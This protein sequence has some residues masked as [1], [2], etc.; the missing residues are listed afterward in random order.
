MRAARTRAALACAVGVAGLTAA[1]TTQAAPPTSTATVAATPVVTPAACA[2]PRV[3]WT[4]VETTPLLA[5]RTA[6][7]TV[8]KGDVVPWVPITVWQPV[9]GATT[10]DVS[11][12]ALVQSLRDREERHFALPGEALSDTGTTV[13]GGPERV[14]LFL[15]VNRV[16]ADF[17]YTCA[18]TTGSGTLMTWNERAVG[19]VGCDSTTKDLARMTPYA[20]ETFRLSC[21]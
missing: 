12:E 6:A 17:T 19:I 15:A 10:S 13:A 9:V 1:C 14:A 21:T 18:G 11:V 20:R 3:T 8:K 4:H 7:V 16:S 2:D 5:Q